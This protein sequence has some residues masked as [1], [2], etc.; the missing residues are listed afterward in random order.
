MTHRAPDHPTLAEVELVASDLDGTLFTSERTVAAETIAS[1]QR[2]AAGGVTVVAATGRSHWTA[3]PRLAPVGV[4]RWAICSNGS[5]LYDFETG[6]LVDRRLLGIEACRAIADLPTRLPGIGLGWEY[7]DGIHRD[8]DFLTAQSGRGLRFLPE[9]PVLHLDPTR[10]IN[11]VMVGHPDLDH[12]SLLAAVRPLLPDDLE[13]SSS[14]SSFIEITAP[15]VEKGTALQSL[16]ERLDLD[17]SRAMAFG[18]Q[19][20]DLGMLAWA[21]FGYAMANAHPLVLLATDRRALHHDDH[22]VARVL[23]SLQH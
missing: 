12:D 6:D 14:G 2:I 20:N 9:E 3:V 11:K 16:S 13:V 18:D 4:I 1:L 5:S 10:D 21:E 23:D 19:Q 7:E 17:P 22:G 15:G 8:A